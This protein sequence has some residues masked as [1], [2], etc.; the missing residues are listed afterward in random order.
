MDVDNVHGARS[1]VEHLIEGGRRTIATI[2][3]PADMAP[4]IDRLAGY[5]DAI[6][7]AGLAVTPDLEALGDFSDVSGEQRCTRCSKRARTSMPCSLR[8]T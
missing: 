3:G 1:A 6:R 8:R 5:R 2:A 4:G 7:A